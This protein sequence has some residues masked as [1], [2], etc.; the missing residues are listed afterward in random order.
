MNPEQIEA[1]KWRMALD[2]APEG[3]HTNLSGNEMV[4]IG[5]LIDHLAS[6]GRLLPEGMV[7]VVKPK[8]WMLEHYNDFKNRGE[9]MRHN[10]EGMEALATALAEAT[11]SAAKKEIK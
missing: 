8:P 5:K 10:E 3:N 9:V 2:L 6:T 4:M 11:I 1:L 7:A